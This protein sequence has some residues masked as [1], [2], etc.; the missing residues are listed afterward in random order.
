[1]GLVTED[2]TPNYS[3]LRESLIEM[4]IPGEVLAPL[5]ESIDSCREAVA[6]HANKTET[7]DNRI[8]SNLLTTSLTDSLRYFKCV[9]QAK[10]KTCFNEYYESLDALI[11]TGRRQ[12]QSSSQATS[13]FGAALDDVESLLN[14][15][16]SDMIELALI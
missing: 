5:S 1:M 12:F 16:T 9:G 8:Q 13:D 3:L 6:W 15:R 11:E 2:L 10:L 4:P 7:A 14:G